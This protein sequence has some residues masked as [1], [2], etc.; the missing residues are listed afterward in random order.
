[1]LLLVP[2]N[3]TRP[4]RPLKRYPGTAL[5]SMGRGR[6]FELAT[7]KRRTPW[8]RSPSA[9]LTIGDAGVAVD[10]SNG[11]R[12][13]GIRWEDCVAVVQNRGSREVVGRDGSVLGVFEDEWRDGRHA[14]GLVDRL[15]PRQLLVPLGS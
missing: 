1:M 2:P 7:V 14:L 15:A 4:Q 10:T 5:G 13:V 6:A 11:A 9:R 3:G 8:A 12:L